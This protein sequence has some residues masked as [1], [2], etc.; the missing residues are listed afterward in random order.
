MAGW[1]LSWRTARPVGWRAKRWKLFKISFNSAQIQAEHRMKLN[2][3]DKFSVKKY[4]Q[5]H[6]VFM[7]SI[8]LS[9]D[10]EKKI[11]QIARNE[12]L[13][14][15][16][17]IRSAIELYFHRYLEADTPFE[18]GKDLFGKYGSGK[19]NLSKDYKNIL[20]DNVRAKHSY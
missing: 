17:V 1:K 6:E 16:E 7:L 8:Q 10:I 12:N 14:N 19:G 2:R 4:I 18:L 5:C 15:T 13:T 20:K 11:E 9:E 3:I